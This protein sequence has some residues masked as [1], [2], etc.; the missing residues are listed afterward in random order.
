VKK[1]YKIFILIF[2][3]A[4]NQLWAQDPFSSPTVLPGADANMS[5]GVAWGDYDNDGWIDLYL[6]KG[7]DVN[8]D[9]YPNYLYKNSSGTL[10]KQNIAGITDI[11][12]A[13]GAATWGDID[14]DGFIDL[15]VAGAQN[16]IGGTKPENNLFLNDGNGSFIDKTGDATTGAI[17]T[18]KEDSRHVGWGDYNN[19]GYLDVFVDNGSITFFGPQK[20]NNS[21]YANDGD[22]TFTR[23][24]EADI[25]NIVYEGSGNSPYRTFGSGFGWTDFN[26]DGYLDIFNCSGGGKDNVLWQNNPSTGQFDDV[27]PGVMKPV[28]TSF[29]SASWVDYDNDGDMDLFA[30]NMIDGNIWHNYLFR[31]NSTT[32]TV[33][34]DSLTGIGPLV[35]DTYESMGS[36]WGD[37]DNDG[38]LDVFVTNRPDNN[39]TQI[40][41]TLY[42]NNGAGS[43]Y[44]FSKAKDYFYPGATDNFQGRGVAMADINNDGFLDLVTAREGEPLLYMNQ[45]NNSNKFALVKLVG[46]G[47]TNRSA[48]GS[49]IKI[50]ANV[51]EQNGVIT[52]MRE[53]MGMTGGGGQ[54]S[55]R[56]HFGLG[57]A[58]KIDDIKV[59]WLNSTGGASRDINSMTDLPVGKI[60][61]FTQGGTSVTS[62]VIKNQNFMYLSGNTKSAIE[63]TSNTDPD[64]GTLTVQK[65]STDPG[66]TFDGNSATDPSGNS[67]TP[68]A[69]VNDRYWSVSES[70]LTGNFTATVYFD[71]SNLPSGLNANNV[72]ILKRA[73]SSSSWTP[74]N[75]EKI[76]NTVYSSGISSFSEFAI[77]YEAN[78]LVE[79]KIFLEGP[80]DTN[81]DMMNT[82]LNDNGYIPLTSPYSEDPRTI[83]SMPA[84][85]VDW[86]LV[87]LRETASGTAVASKSALLYKDG[88]VVNDDAS[89]GVINMPV[90][91]GNYFIVIKHRN[92]LAVMSASAV[93]LNG[94]TSS[95]Y[96]FT[97]A[98]SQFYGTGGS[99]ELEPNVWGMIAGDTDGSGV[100]DAADRNATWNDRNSSGYND[101]D[102]DLSGVVDAGDRNKTWNNR[103][104]NSQLP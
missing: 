76:G 5:Q 13:S 43:G 57:T 4:A 89:S 78:V 14:N 1:F 27:T 19:D 6:T 91:D 38:D 15:Y 32:T 54:N 40:P 80:Y 83:S 42:T 102:V 20:G 68:N 100:V 67:V 2:A 97:T 82:N 23:K 26:N 39:Q 99:I 58:T 12:L 69:V 10:V 60:I 94:T 86:V 62:N 51:P 45:A 56:Q 7:N 44:T 59:L 22:G 72:V 71:A 49:R 75:T 87:E 104:K 93:S 77:G 46:T 88:R 25:G 52:Q 103:N 73:N 30:C 37:V 21:F 28:Q 3:L 61:I 36:A 9:K 79:T 33:S 17:V 34:F 55:L 81:I 64:G 50:T 8:G 31:N 74:L 65:F 101:S 18:D 48:I 11:T 63:F 70:G 53:V 47:T 29:I 16:G 92:H 98:E 66:G 90:S 41:S 96:D 85:V 24:G 95:L 35:T 84:G